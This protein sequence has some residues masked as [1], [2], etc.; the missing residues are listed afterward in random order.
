MWYSEGQLGAQGVGGWPTTQEG[1]SLEL[2]AP[3]SLHVRFSH[4]GA[5]HGL[6][7]PPR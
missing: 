3:G 7:W 2:S 1:E 4:L 5:A 6:L